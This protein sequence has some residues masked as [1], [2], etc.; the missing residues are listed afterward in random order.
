MSFVA[1]AVAT[2]V[3]SGAV[4]AYGAYE[5]AKTQADAARYG[6]DIANQQFQTINA[7][8]APWRQAGEN[9]LTQIAG[10]GDF[11]NKQFGPEDL[12][13]G[14]APNYEFMK[15]QGLGAVQNF[16]TVGGGL[17]SGNTLKAISDYTTNYAQSGY[18]QAFQNFTTNQ[19]NIFNRLASIAGLGQTANATTAQAGTSLAG[20]EAGL[21]AQAGAARAGGIVGGANA[22]SGGINNAMSWYTLPKILGMGTGTGAPNEGIT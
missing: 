18:Q 2:G 13:R 10:M 4:G 6:A 16:S 22:I 1:A 5:G 14:L 7:Q 19:S 15:Q 8:Q 11:F 9:A 21:V 17:F 12:A 20:T 3:V